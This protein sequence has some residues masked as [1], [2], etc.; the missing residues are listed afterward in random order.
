M[1]SFFKSALNPSKEYTLH[2]TCE[3]TDVQGYFFITAFAIH[4]SVWQI[5]KFG[6]LVVPSPSHAPKIYGSTIK[7]FF[8]PLTTFINGS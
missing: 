2:P 4:E 1:P 8:S 3:Y 6:L 5:V 7:F